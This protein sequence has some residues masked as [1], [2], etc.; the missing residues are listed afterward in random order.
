ML[1]S[2]PTISNDIN[3]LAWKDNAL[4]LFLSTTHET[5]P[6]QVI[7]QHRKRLATT[8]TLAKTA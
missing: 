5:R 2:K 8:L 3:Q 6:D 1:Y 7:V 4:V